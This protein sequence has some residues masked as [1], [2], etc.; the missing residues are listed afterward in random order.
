MPTAKP[1]TTARINVPRASMIARSM[2]MRTRDRGA[3]DEL[4][5]PVHILGA[6]PRHLSDCETR[7]QQLRET[8]PDV[9][10]ERRIDVARQKRREIPCQRG[11]GE[12]RLDHRFGEDDEHRAQG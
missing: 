6:P 11:N 1:L 9:A 4:E 10:E 3:E 7:H 5:A 2:T 12:Q 8:K